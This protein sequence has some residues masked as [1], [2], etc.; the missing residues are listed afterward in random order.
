VV[1]AEDD[2]GAFTVHR[3]TEVL[4][5][6]RWWVN[7][8]LDGD[9]TPEQLLAALHEFDGQFRPRQVPI[10]FRLQQLISDLE[11][12]HDATAVEEAWTRFAVPGAS[13]DDPRSDWSIRS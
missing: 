13:K 5:I 6:V 7:R 2:A 3:E 8:H 11:Q 9:M 1:E 12:S 10:G 4:E